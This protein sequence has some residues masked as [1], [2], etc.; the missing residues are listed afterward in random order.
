MKRNKSKTS[1]KRGFTLIELLVVVLIIGILAAVAVPQYK[2]AVLKTQMATFLPLVKA[3]DSAQK[4]YHLT[5]GEYATT[6]A[7]LDVVPPPGEKNFSDRNI[8]Y[9]SG[10]HC[11][12]Y[13]NEENSSFSCW[14]PNDKWRW[15]KYYKAK[16]IECWYYGHVLE[17]A[18]CQALGAT[19]CSSDREYCWLRQ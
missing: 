12:M 18:A 2:K 4:V 7:Q 8:L 1:C 13:I 15:E 11:S 17:K 19:F 16:E 10:A 6:F 3:V 14:G 5:N 9:K